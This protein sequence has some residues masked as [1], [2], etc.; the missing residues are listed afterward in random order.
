MNICDILELLVGCL[1]C[2]KPS[3]GWAGG[4]YIHRSQVSVILSSS[5]HLEA[6]LTDFEWTCFNTI[7]RPQGNCVFPR[8]L[9][10]IYSFV[11]LGLLQSKLIKKKKTFYSI[12]PK[13]LFFQ[14][15]YKLWIHAYWLS[16]CLVKLIFYI[17]GDFS[18]RQEEFLSNES[19]AALRQK[20]NIRQLHN[21]LRHD[22]KDLIYRLSNYYINMFYLVL[23]SSEIKVWF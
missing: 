22:L 13:S 15:R 20:I 9:I 10:S 11:A 16:Y 1:P 17:S 21:D 12:S 5:L 18:L 2:T 3:V 19:Y 14:S 6:S 8:A 7:S 4:P 23:W